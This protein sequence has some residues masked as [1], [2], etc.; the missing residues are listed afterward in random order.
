MI[1][2][3]Q[4]QACSAGATKMLESVNQI[5]R[6]M[7]GNQQENELICRHQWLSLQSPSLA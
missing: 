2:I 1:A 3:A 6:Q 7:R 5:A 4:E